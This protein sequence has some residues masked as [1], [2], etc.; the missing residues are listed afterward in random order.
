M[1]PVECSSIVCGEIICKLHSISGRKNSVF[2]PYL[3]RFTKVTYSHFFFIEKLLISFYAKENTSEVKSHNLEVRI[4]ITEG[5]ATCRASNN[6][7]NKAPSLS[8]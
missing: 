4:P 1:N 6:A 2:A 5:Q 8:C 3:K 7:C